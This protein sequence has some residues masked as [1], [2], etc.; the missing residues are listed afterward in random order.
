MVQISKGAKILDAFMHPDKSLD[1]I[2]ASQRKFNEHFR[3]VEL[4]NTQDKEKATKDLCL[5]MISEIDELLRETNFKLHRKRG[6]RITH[7]NL[8]EEWI[9]IFKYWLSIGQVWGFSVDNFLSEYERKSAVCEQRYQQ[10]MELDLV[11]HEKLVALDIDGV[12]AD[13]P[14]SFQNFIKDE[15]GVWVDIKSYDLYGEYGAVLGQDKVRELKHQ[16]RESGQKQNIPLCPGANDLC[17]RIHQAGYNIVFLTSRPVKQYG[18]IF[19]DT[20]TWLEKNGLKQPG[21][22]IIFDEEKNYKATKEFPKLNFMVEDNLAFA[23]TIAK[24]GYKVYLIDRIYNQKTDLHPNI[25]RITELE[26][27]NV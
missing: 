20:M 17:D 19:A 14:K 13:Y 15:T 9:D 3:A 24:L 16:Y 18:R 7:S 25:E 2:W 1:E 23:G 21:D 8:R 11:N 26:D 6:E 27:I 22:A 10:E 5:E 12:L 4:M